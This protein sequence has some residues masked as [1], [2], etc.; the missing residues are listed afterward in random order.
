MTAN[1]EMSDKK[2]LS[3]I[4]IAREA[5]GKPIQ[6]IA[7][8]LDIPQSEIEQYGKDKAKLS[9]DFIQ[10]VQHRPNGKLIL[11]TAIN[12]TP[13]G[14]GK[15]TT[16]IGLGDALTQIGKKSAIC[17]REPSL[18]PCFGMKGGAAGGGYSQVIPME[19]INL[20]FTGDFHA[21]GLAHNLLSAALD[22]HLHQG[23]QLNID[24]RRITWRRVMDM[25]DRALRQINLGL[26]GP[27]NSIPRESGFDITVASEIMAIFCL[28]NSLAEL[29]QKMG[30][31]VV[32][33]TYDKKPVTAKELNVH[34]A[35]TVLLKDAF[36]PNLVQ[37]LESTPAFVHGGPFANIAH[38][39]NSVSATK[40]SMKLADYTVTEAG[41]GADLGAEK[42]LNI[43]CRKAGLVPDAV[44]LVA[45]IRALKLHGGVELKDL[46]TE[47]CEAVSRGVEN[48]KKH[49]ENIHQFGLPVVVAV[50]KF[51]TDTD[52]EV[53][54]VQDKCD[55]LNVKVI[56][57]DHWANGG[58]G[59]IDL[60]HEVVDQ[61][62]NHTTDFNYLYEDDMSLWNKIKTIATKIY[63]ANDITADK[64]LRDQIHALQEGG[65]GHLPICMAKTQYSFSTDPGL[66]GR[67]EGFDVPLSEVRLAAGA[68][69]IVVLTGDVMTMPGLPKKP[70]AEVIDID[71]ETGNVI[72]LF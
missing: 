6:E 55:Y 56:P 72:G 60:A 34:G 51:V 18:G 42:F 65:Y 19:E 13:A 70:S 63:G 9:L 38:G 28:A 58:A 50:N 69:F 33:Q 11:V 40:L 62:E 31:I 45:T 8:K 32:A 14:E 36:K 66:R 30:D 44:V 71:D 27:G 10:S 59:A 4:E 68:G 64:K 12:P 67:P 35:M 29:K 26:G 48:L 57:C 2:H 7:E 5:T 24:P 49:I 23:N 39:C 21:I 22:N 1:K 53:K 37:T 43:K 15:T 47:D 20:H 17:L 16:T 3:D 25:N 41:F 54:T 61:I 52:N 46:G